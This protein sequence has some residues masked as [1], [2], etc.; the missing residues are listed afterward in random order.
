MAIPTYPDFEAPPIEYDPAPDPVLQDVPLNPPMI[1]TADPFNRVDGQNRD[2]VIAAI[3][4]WFR[5]IFLPWL[6]AWTEFWTN[7]RTKLINDWNTFRLS[8]VNWLNGWTHAIEV[9]IDDVLTQMENY[10]LEHTINTISIGEIATGA[11]GSYADASITGTINDVVVNF[12]IP[13]GYNGRGWFSIDQ[14]IPVDGSIIDAVVVNN[15]APNYHDFAI[16]VGSGNYGY[17]TDVISKISENQWAVKVQ[18]IDTLRGSPGIAYAGNITVDFDDAPSGDV[19]TGQLDVEQMIGAFK[20]TTNA[21]CWVRIYASEAH[22]IADENR[23]ID[24]PIDVSTDHGVYLDYVSIP[25]S[26]V[27]T[28]SPGVMI[29]DTGDGIWYSITNTSNIV[30]DISVNLDYRIFRENEII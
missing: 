19:K 29:S 30:S 5:K 11:P 3:R 2:T 26:L 18:Y 21:Q 13:R 4:A 10:I 24:E 22:M 7:W 9:W 20:I 28:L 14:Q 15:D 23:L 12:T 17:I 25:T 27:K 6:A 1:G 16:S 8:I